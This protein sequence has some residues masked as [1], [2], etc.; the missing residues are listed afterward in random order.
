MAITDATDDGF[1]KEHNAYVAIAS[2][3][4]CKNRC[5]THI[6]ISRVNEQKKFAEFA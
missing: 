2:D 4:F 6:I 1:A 5:T 3:F